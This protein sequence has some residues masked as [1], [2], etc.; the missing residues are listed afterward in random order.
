M[1]P[2][3]WLILVAYLSLLLE[4]VVFP[5]PSEASTYQ[6]FF[7]TEG[8][9]DSPGDGSL[10]RARQ[11]SGLVKSCCYF[12]P[13]ALGV[14]LFLIPLG[15][16][17]YPE[18]I[19]SLFPVSALQTSLFTGFGALAVVLGRSITF[20]SVLQLRRQKRSGKLSAQGIFT[21]SRNP[22]LVGMYVFY[23][24]NALL[25]P[26]WVL[27]IGFLPYVINMHRRVLM[28]ENHL[29]ELIGSEYRVYLERVARYLPLGIGSR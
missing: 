5:I 23:I 12:L 8:E 24:G 26:C 13:T 15:A 20:G 9:V 21:L 1:T 29:A 7:K 11:R 3:T 27:I 18:I 25:F 22:G 19:E 17:V 16:S 2:V 14:V 10:G 28:E 4:L 6:L